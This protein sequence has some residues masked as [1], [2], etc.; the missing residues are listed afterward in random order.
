MDVGDHLHELAADPAD[1]LLGA[2]PPVVNHL[3]QVSALNVVAHQDK[4]GIPFEIRAEGILE[5]YRLE[6]EPGEEKLDVLRV[7]NATAATAPFVISVTCLV[8]SGGAAERVRIRIPF[9][10]PP[11][12]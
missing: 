12:P 7:R 1:L 3:L 9:P 6:L 11:G 5:R 10:G 2:A 8:R 4:P